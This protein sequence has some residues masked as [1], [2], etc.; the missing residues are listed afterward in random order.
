[1]RFP[2]RVRWRRRPGPRDQGDER[3]RRRGPGRRRRR[4]ATAASSRRGMPGKSSVPPRNRATATSSAAM[5]AADA[6]LPIRPA[7][8]AMRSAGNRPSSGARKSSR[9]AHTGPAA[10]W[11]TEV[12]RG[13]SARTG[14]GDACRGCPAGLQR[15]IDEQDGRVHDALRMDHDVDRVVATSYSQRASMISRPLLASVAESIVILAPMVQVGCLSARSGVTAASSRVGGIEERSARGGEH[16]TRD[17]GLRFTDEALPDGGV[18]RVD[19]AEP[20]EGRRKRVGRV[21][22]RALRGVAAAPRP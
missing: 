8:R 3:C 19:R 20:C 4:S 1:M 21:L 15:A 7:S 17:P 22:R 18:L 12:A 2:R 9:A 11:V 5:S 6:R 14:W 10:A 13:T 16:Q